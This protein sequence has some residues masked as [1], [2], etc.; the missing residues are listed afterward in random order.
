MLEFVNIKEIELSWNVLDL[1]SQFA[2][3]RLDPSI[4]PMYSAASD[5]TLSLDISTS[6]VSHF[7]AERCSFWNSQY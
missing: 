2:Y 3:G 7:N 6:V 5:E 4:W 1:W